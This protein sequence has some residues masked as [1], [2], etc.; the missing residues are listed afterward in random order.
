MGWHFEGMVEVDSLS[1]AILCLTTS[2]D[3]FTG[4]AHGGHGTYFANIDPTT[5]MKVKLSDRLKPGFE[6]PLRK[7]GEEIF[8][9]TY[10][11]DSI[12]DAAQNYQFEDGTF[13]LNTNY[14]FTRNG[15]RFLYNIYEIAPY[16][17]GIQEIVIPYEDVKLWM[18]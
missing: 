2:T 6:E 1:I 10:L 15:I 5:G 16:A 11:S 8:K 3:Y 12:S 9:T 18:K 17:A 14:T 13:T 4:G 7:A